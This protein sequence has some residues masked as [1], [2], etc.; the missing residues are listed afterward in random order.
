MTPLGSEDYSFNAKRLYLVSLLAEVF[1]QK[2][3]MTFQEPSTKIMEAIIDLH[4]D[5]MFFLIVI[6][7]F[8][9]GMI[10][11][12]VRYFGVSNSSTVRSNFTHHQI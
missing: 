3:Q 7:I 4:H 2:G 5:V 6:G 1:P 10:F 9:L 12:I 8:V 11:T